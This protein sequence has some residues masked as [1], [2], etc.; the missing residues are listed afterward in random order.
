MDE[1]KMRE[2]EEKL[3]EAASIGDMEMLRNL[4]EV[5]NVDVNSQNKMNGRTAL[6]WGAKRNHQTVVQYLLSHGAD[7]EALDNEGKKAG[8]LATNSD[9]HSLLG[10]H[11]EV[12]QQEKL[13][14]TPNYLAHPPFPY[15]SKSDLQTSVDKLSLSANMNNHNSV[16]VSTDDE[17]V[18]KVRVAHVEDPDFIEVELP[19][20]HLRYD[21]LLNLMCAELG[22][23]KQLVARIRKLP[24]T[25]VRK[26]KDVARLQ[27]FQELE[28]VL[29]NRAISASS[30]GYR[31][32]VT[33]PAL[34]NEQILY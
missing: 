5:K 21:A 16:P 11:G 15:S 4:V 13:P 8:Q 20:V 19:R 18:L 34:T 26:D 29:T 10:E 9:I 6:H 23:D 1:I 31:G 17:L 28:L 7:T 30:R 25:V 22:V 24:N 3:R 32:I 27:D 33:S 12:D 14:I 2:L